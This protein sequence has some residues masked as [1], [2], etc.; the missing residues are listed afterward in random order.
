MDQ[1]K[2]VI[3]KYKEE[4]DGYD[5]L[6]QLHDELNRKY[7]ILNQHYN[8]DVVDVRNQLQS[9]TLAHATE[10]Q[11]LQHRLN[12]TELM[13]KNERIKSQTTQDQYDKLQ[14]YYTGELDNINDKYSIELV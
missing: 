10:V 11:E 4:L 1:Q 7:N 14:N 5:Q 6:K 13:L 9:T 3:E 2:Q 8:D 12:E